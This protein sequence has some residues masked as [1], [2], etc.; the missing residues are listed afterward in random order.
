MCFLWI[1]YF[2]LNYE[3]SFKYIGH[4]NYC[5]IYITKQVR[6]RWPSGPWPEEPISCRFIWCLEILLTNFSSP[7]ECH[8]ASHL[9]PAKIFQAC[10]FQHQYFS[11]ASWY[12]LYETFILGPCLRDHVPAVKWNSTRDP[13]LDKGP[14]SGHIYTS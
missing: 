5:V 12:L 14:Q 2:K 8:C 11:R 1:K 3:N 13:Y 7:F 6:N 9:L 4:S 10:L